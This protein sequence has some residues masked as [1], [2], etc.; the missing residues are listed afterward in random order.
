MPL[1]ILILASEVAPFAKT[2]GLADVAGALPNA[3]AARGHDVRVMMPAHAA[4]EDAI[5]RRDPA[6][7]TTDLTLDVP[8]GFGPIRAGVFQSTLA[9]SAVPVYFIAERDLFDRTTI[10]GYRDDPYR[11]AFFSRAALDLAIGAQA[12]RPDVVHAHDWQTGAAILWLATA[13]L[14]DDRYRGLPTV[15]TIHNLAYQGLA[16]WHVLDYLGVRTSRLVEEGYNE[17]NFMARGIYHATMINTV[18][19][20]YAR[21][22][23]TKDGGAGL[24]ALLRHRQYDVHGVL[25]GVD[26]DVWNPASD[27]HLAHPFDHTSID[28]RRENKRALQARAQLPER[29]DVPIVAMVT[30]L[31]Q[32]KGIDLV[33]HVVHLLMNGGAGDAQ[34]IVLGSGQR[35]YE[36]MFAYLAGYHRKKMSAFLHYAPDLAPLIYGG[37]DVFLMPSLFEPCGLGQLIAMRY[38]SLPVV[39]AT[40][41]LADT[42]RDG[43]TGFVFSGFSTDECWA[44]LSRAIDLYRDDPATWRGMQEAA[45]S[46][47]FSWPASAMG[48]EQI[49]EWAIARV[50]G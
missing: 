13:G 44:A 36:E 33:G 10:Y 28:H 48:Y 42:V 35:H 18:S 14:G 24:D 39:R 37:S 23:L 11:Y 26:Y 49:Y 22:I 19:P 29:D 6:Y 5:A 7:A 45:M 40:G 25:N 1:R 12:W 41:G 8:M 15:F 27:R 17:V 20:N 46:A 3:L 2:G 30:R 9:G 43:E 50:R 32:Q 38:G 21:E 4:V 31:D 47:D 34:F 16:P